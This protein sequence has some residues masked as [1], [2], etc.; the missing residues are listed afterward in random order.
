MKACAIGDEGRLMNEPRSGGAIGA[1]HVVRL[2]LYLSDVE[3]LPARGGK[4]NVTA[5]ALAC[6]FDRGVL[7]TNGECKRLLQEAIVAKGLEGLTERAITPT[8]D[9]CRRLE[10]QV[11]QLE[12]RIAAISAENEALRT[13]LKR[14]GHVE[15]HM[16]ATGRLPR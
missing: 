15:S 3:A 2:R 12:Q 16:I 11:S 10:Q 9:R 1:E 8:D 6:G 13:K 7:Y 4:L 5:V 14:L